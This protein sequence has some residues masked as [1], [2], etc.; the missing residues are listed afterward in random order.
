MTSTLPVTHESWY[1]FE[2]GRTVGQR[3]PE[4]G[5]ILQDEEHANGA[6]ITLECGCS[7]APFAITCSIYG[8]MVHTRYFPTEESAQQAFK[9]MKFELANIL[10]LI[11]NEND[12]EA[13][14]KLQVVGKMLLDFIERFP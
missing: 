2:G 8:W 6:R 14:T 10:R 12:P 4:N 11:P 13:E 3:G 1:P 7:A 5:V 9:E